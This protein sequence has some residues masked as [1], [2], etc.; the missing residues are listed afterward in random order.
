VGSNPATPTRKRTAH[1]GGFFLM[2]PWIREEDAPASDGSR[3]LG[4]WIREEDAQASDGSRHLGPWIRE[5]DAP[6]S[7]GSR[8]PDNYLL[9]SAA[10]TS[11]I[12]AVFSAAPL[13]KLSPQTKK[14]STLS[15]SGA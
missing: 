15:K 8:H 13:R 12:C 11:A 9:S 1:R 4:P 14:S 5:E 6:A 10:T 3:H 7:D 2:G